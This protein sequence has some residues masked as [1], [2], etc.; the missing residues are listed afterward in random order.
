MLNIFTERAVA[1]A[2]VKEA[3]GPLEK[4]SI[5]DISDDAGEVELPPPVAKR[6][7]A[8]TTADTGVKK[9]RAQK[10]IEKSKVEKKA[11]PKDRKIKARV[12]K[13]SVIQTGTKS[14]YFPEAQQQTW[15][16]AM[17]G[18]Q[19]TLSSISVTQD[20]A[21]KKTALIPKSPNQLPPHLE[22]PLHVI[23]RQWTPVKNTVLTLDSSSP[24]VNGEPKMTK[25]DIF[26]SMVDVMRYSTESCQNSR[27]ASV[28]ME[29]RIGN[30][31]TKKRAI[32]VRNPY[33]VLIVA[34]KSARRPLVSSR[35]SCPAPAPK[36][37]Y[38]PGVSNLLGIEI[39][40]SLATY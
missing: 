30:C 11:P 29:D 16:E 31:L 23:R 12:V 4:T 25:K 15:S 39:G 34:A 2:K 40:T 19:E 14:K 36:G 8:K 28:S 38:V 22:P 37:R 32:E 13:S 1:V 27:E 33:K 7:T 35:L 26:G 20:T 10:T 6:R 5:W 18:N 17:V 24:L 9:P 21:S 3:Q